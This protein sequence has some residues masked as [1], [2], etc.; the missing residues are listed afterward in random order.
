MLQMSKII[1]SRDNWKRKAVQR[2]NEI[3]EFRKTQKRYQEKIVE[4]N[5]QI[6]AMEQ[7]CSEKKTTRLVASVPAPDIS[8]AQQVRTL[9]IMLVLQ[10]VVSIRQVPRILNLFHTETPLALGWIPHFTSVINWTLR[11]GLGML[12]QVSPISEPWLAIRD[13]SI[14]IG[15]KKALVVLRVTMDAL[16]RKSKAIQ[17]TDCECIGVKV[18]EKVDGKSISMELEEIFTHAGTPNAIIKDCESSLQKGV[19]LW[20]KNSDTT[21]AVIED[22]GHVMANA[23][24]AQ[25]EETTNY[26]RFTDQYKQGS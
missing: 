9:C 22:I 5:A 20:S 2:A 10:A 25:F 4:L 17:L 13:H 14:D 1:Q 8:Q 19:R 12:K 15:T 16:E 24:K 18:C 23:L 21:V 11:L 3:R 26:K 6:N 7:A